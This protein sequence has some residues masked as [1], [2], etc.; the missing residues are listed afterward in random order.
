MSVALQNPY[1][2]YKH[3][4]VETAP[5]ERLLIMLYDGA[6]KFVLQTRQALEAK[7]YEEAHRYN[8]RVQDILAELNHTLDQSF[9]EIP[10][11][12]SRLYDFYQRQMILANLK[13]DPQL[14]QPVLTFLQD[15]RTVWEKAALLSKQ[16]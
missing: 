10:L 6:I 7:N 4:S 1:E 14:L 3:A 5:P 8:L 9:G 11:R 13:K 16:G 15:F 12:L 2:R